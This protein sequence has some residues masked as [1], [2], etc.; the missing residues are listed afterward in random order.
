LALAA[1]G[2]ALLGTFYLLAV[3]ARGAARKGAAVIRTALGALPTPSAGPLTFQVSGIASLQGLLDL[4][5]ALNRTP[6]VGSTTVRSYYDGEATI[7]VALSAAVRA[8]ELVANWSRLAS[9]SMGISSDEGASVL[10]VKVRPEPSV[11]PLTFQVSGIP[12]F[13]G[14]L[15]LNRALNRTPAVGSTTVRSYY[16]A[17]ATISVALSAPVRAEELVANWSRLA[18][19]N[20]SVSSEDQGAS[21]LG[22]KVR[23]EPFAT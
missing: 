14:L 20:M 11:G 1:L 15:D 8:E 10:G 19:I 9:V 5:R 12:S 13:Q 4:N 16:D 7:S 21:V 6:A 23:P 22:V 18:A 2:A 17:E 3:A